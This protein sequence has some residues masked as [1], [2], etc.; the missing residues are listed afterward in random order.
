MKMR[1][2]FRFPVATAMLI[3]V[4]CVY[5]VAL[6]ETQLSAA[7]HAVGTKPVLED[8]YPERRL[9]FPDG[10]TGLPDLTYSTVSGFRPLTLDLYLPGRQT[11][12]GAP[13]ILYVH[14]GGWTSGHTRH[15]GAFEN[16]PGVL[17]S[18]AARGYVVASINYR[19]SAEAPSPAAVQD[20]KS[21]VRWLRANASRF[22]ID[23]QLIGIWGGSAGGQLAALAGTSC[24]VQALDPPA[25]DSNTPAE[26]DCVQG[27]VAWYGVFDF[28]PLA[29]NVAAP[30][31]VARYLGC[32]GG[33]CS[34]QKIALASA[35]RHV[36]RGDPP[37]LLI[38]GALDKTV[39]VRQS[40][41][42]HAA[43]QASAVRS[44]LIVFPDVDHSFI[45]STPELTRSVSL[46]ALQA[47]IDF[48]DAT[49]RRTDQERI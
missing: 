26:S 3:A 29:K 16:W 10:V 17:A 42:F 47:T 23:R 32:G 33:A 38:H 20:V 27:V 31:N 34:D 25:A 22:G 28:T 8:R 21:A 30:P 5:A 15:S 7:E 24:G 6:G 36:D 46:R 40:E 9:A 11:S 48:F 35:I 13:V 49:L 19:L 1:A 37:F 18:L 45:G 4:L 44:Q 2:A 43:L 14:G 39:A 12:R 41:K